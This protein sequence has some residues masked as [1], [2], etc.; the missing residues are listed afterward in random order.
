[1][2]TKA[3]GGKS[4]I[5]DDFMYGSN[6][7][8]SDIYIRMGFLR[9]VY[10]ILSCQLIFTTIVGAIFWYLEP[11]KNF[12]QTNNVLLMVSAF[13]SL[14]LIIALS[15]KS[16]VV[17][18]NYILLAVF[19]LCESILVGSVVGQ[20]QF[21]CSFPLRGSFCDPS[22]RLT[23][24]VTIALTTYTMQSK[25]DFSTWGAGLFSVLLVLIMAGFLQIFLQSEM[26]DM[27]IAVGGA[28]LFSLFIIF[29]THMIMSKVT[30]E[31][32]IHASV[33]L[34]LDII[35]LFLH[36]LRALGD[37]RN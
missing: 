19:T 31:E 3:D 33:N 8:A 18:T 24:A 17:P 4:G 7:A 37:R 36:I 14:G 20:C 11:Q 25:R 32:Y 26:V 34:Y 9:K 23:A 30:P 1:M 27:A 35:N 10:S 12:P 22:I 29:D 13:S 6:V 28:V 2:D 5:I 15:L 16:R 21:L